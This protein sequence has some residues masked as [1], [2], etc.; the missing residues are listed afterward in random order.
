MNKKL[1]FSSTVCLYSLP[2]RTS[3]FALSHYLRVSSPCER[4]VI[5]A[6]IYFFFFSW[7]EFEN[8]VK[9]KKITVR[10]HVNPFIAE[11]FIKKK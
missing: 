1:S 3:Y 10:T 6:H 9:K 8:L 7:L 4:R 2:F 11:I 5:F